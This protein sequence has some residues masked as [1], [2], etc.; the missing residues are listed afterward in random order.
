MTRIARNNEREEPSKEK[1]RAAKEQTRRNRGASV[2]KFVRR[3]TG[4]EH[5]RAARRRVRIPVPGF[6]ARYACSTRNV[7]FCSRVL[8]LGAERSAAEEEEE[9]EEEEEGRE[10]RRREEGR[11]KREKRS[12]CARASS[13]FMCGTVTWVRIVDCAGARQRVG[14]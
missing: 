5:P 14:E 9:E 8:R 3:A 4:N 12:A 2:E 7:R 10:K 13:I 6:L 11:R 1:K